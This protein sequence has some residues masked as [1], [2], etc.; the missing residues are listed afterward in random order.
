MSHSIAPLLN[1]LNPRELCR[2]C[3]L[4]NLPSYFV[5]S[6]SLSNA[7]VIRIAEISGIQPWHANK[8]AVCRLLLTI[9][10][11]LP[12]HESHTNDLILLAFSSKKSY[13]LGLWTMASFAI[14]D[15]TLLGLVPR[16]ILDEGGGIGDSSGRE[17]TMAYLAQSGYI[18]PKISSEKA[19]KTGFRLRN[20]RPL[21][22]LGI[23]RAWFERCCQLHGGH[24]ERYTT[25]SAQAL[26]DLRVIDCHADLLE[27]VPAP[28]QC[29][30][31]ALSYVWGISA[32]PTK[33]AV[34]QAH[35]HPSTLPAVI[36]DAMIV[37][38]ELGL[39]YLWVDRYCIRQ[40]DENDKH[41]Q[42]RNMD[43]IYWNAQLT[44]IAASGNNPS[45][46]LP[47]VRLRPRAPLPRATVLGATCFAYP[48]VPTHCIRTSKWMTRAWT[49]QESVFSR[50]RLYFTDRQIYF[51]CDKVRC[52]EAV[53]NNANSWDG[54][55]GLTDP[56]ILP[57]IAPS[58][59]ERHIEEYS[60]RS[61]TYDQDILNAF[62][63]VFRAYT[64]LVDPTYHIWGVP[65]INHHPY[66]S[67]T[68]SSRI[69]SPIGIR[70][71][72]LTRG[73]LWASV[74]PSQRR[75]G[76]PTWSWAGWKGEVMWP[77][78]EAAPALF[79][80]LEFKNW[81]DSWAQ[82]GSDDLN[83]NAFY[84]ETL[85]PVLRIGALT[86]Q[87]KFRYFDGSVAALPLSE[88]EGYFTLW[89][90]GAQG[91]LTNFVMGRLHLSLSV[92]EIGNY[93]V[94]DTLA[95]DCV[96]LTTRSALVVRTNGV[97]W[98]R[99]GSVHCTNSFNQRKDFFREA[100]LEEFFNI[101]K[102]RRRLELH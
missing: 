77:R 28:P 20:I 63:G 29:D 35:V 22:D 80:D 40:D 14:A 39:R 87:A 72:G 102:L 93:R 95:L 76:F 75:L 101:P 23:A 69:Q 99:I 61:I 85:K 55:S 54:I 67:T 56:A 10:S 49:Y 13:G 26:T 8:C 44:I 58:T 24:H 68:L 84:S 64:Q 27:V 16:G 78:V 81:D 11:S 42:I 65:I 4:L 96:W 59:I 79:D 18:A 97:A 52:M 6:F 12:E 38:R 5:E 89:S 60:K 53:Q 19:A 47:G 25:P 74:H 17:A 15:Q 62:L 45:Y 94:G 90:T 36:Q 51:E 57:S 46:G 66:N 71:N 30:Y 92:E 50:R 41:I 1:P 3:L 37:V 73:L 91:N 32:T 83:K 34:G 82:F 86:C 48:P 9:T 70:K 2:R 100:E 33:D 31:L 98:H 7:S 88:N 21:A 43:L